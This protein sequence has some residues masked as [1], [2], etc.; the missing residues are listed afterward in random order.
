MFISLPLTQFVD[1]VLITD[2]KIKKS[3]VS[4]ENADRNG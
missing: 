3:Y 1:L 2:A 4:L